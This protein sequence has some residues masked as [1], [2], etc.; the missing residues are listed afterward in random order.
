ESNGGGAAAV[1]PPAAA[2]AGD[3]HAAPPPPAAETKIRLSL[4]AKLSFLI[5]SLVVLAVAL[6]G[7]FLLRQQQQSLTAEMTKRRLTIAE[8]F[9]SSAKS[10]L[11]TNDELT[12]AVLV[13]EAMKDPDVASSLVPASQG[14]IL[15]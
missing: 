14:T 2:K 10:P 11:L 7:V 9:A 4:K 13:K 12:L 8:D 1:H 3:G 6:V 5:T 15:A